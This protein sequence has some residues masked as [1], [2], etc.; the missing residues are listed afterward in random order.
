MKQVKPSPWIFLSIAI[1]VVCAIVGQLPNS[2]SS[3]PLTIQL[4][5]SLERIGQTANFPTTSL[6]NLAAARG[7]Y[8]SFQL[9]VRAGQS[10][11][12]NVNVKMSNLYGGVNQVIPQANIALY[13]EHYV[14]V[15]Q[16]SPSWRSTINRSLGAGWYAD[17][18]IPFT[19]PGTLTT[20]LDSSLKAFPFTVQPQQN[21]PIWV[22]VLVPRN[23]LPGNYTGRLM[24]TSDQGRAETQVALK[25]WNFALPLKPSLQSSFELWQANTKQ[26]NEELLKHKLMPKTTQ[27]ADQAAL[28][29]QGLTS[30]SLGYWS[31][32]D[33]NTCTMRAAPAVET[34]RA[35]AAQYQPGLLTY[36]YTADEIDACPGLYS[37]MLQ[38]GKNLHQAGVKNLVTMTPNPALYDDGTGRSAVDIW[39][40]LPKMYDAARDRVAQVLQKGDQVWS[41]NTLVQDD[42]SPKWEIDFAPIN[43]RIQPGFISQ[44][45]NLTGLLYWRADLWTQDP[46]H[47]VQTYQTN[48]QGQRHDYPGEGMLVYPGQPLGIDGVVPSMRLKWLRD[49][50][51]DYEYVQILKGLGRGDWALAAA[52][53]VGQDWQHWT[54]DPQALEAIRQSL[55]TEI[56]RLLS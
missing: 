1:I 35:R 26:A 55:G 27:P 12:T 14:P 34:L 22:D 17:G 18:L 5:P 48:D 10:G 38:W 19:N 41:Y 31:G 49:G 52:Q 43:F 54:S 53:S 24:V 9:V 13:R 20:A 23:A 39:V 37:Q 7:E 47:D 2:L 11:L 45:L 25:V 42:T 50:V 40:L 3:S 4:V 51:E 15:K 30:A 46:W 8:E 56:D 36:N 16:P 29:Q 28:I 32:A 33:I 6:T 21:Q 44:S